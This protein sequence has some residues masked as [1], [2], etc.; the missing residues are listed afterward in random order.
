MDAIKNISKIPNKYFLSTRTDNL[1]DI[2]A[3]NFPTQ[4]FFDTCQ[5]IR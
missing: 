3:Q 5:A 2:R 1:K 4:T